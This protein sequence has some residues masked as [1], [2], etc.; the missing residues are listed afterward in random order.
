MKKL[1]AFFLFAGLAAIPAFGDSFTILGGYVLPR[2]HSDVYQQ[3]E[4]ETTFRVSDLN[5]FGGTVRYDKFLG[6]FVNI[7]GGVSFYDDTTTVSD[8]DF[9][10]TDGF[11]VLRDI[12]LEIV[13]LE[14][15]I[16]LLPAG[17][18]VPVIPYVGGGFGLYYWRYEEVGDF[19]NN[20]NGAN[21]TIITG[22]AFSDGWDPGFHIEGGV[23]IPVGRSLA[24][25]GEAKYWQAHG[26]LDPIG[27]DPS[28]EPLDLSG[29]Q[30]S[31]GVSI[32]F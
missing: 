6:N 12:R 11:P 15:S 22:R 31:G 23:H 9:V 1:L 26:N 17:R 24:V 8:V 7:S 32:W 3:N 20:R 13:P 5:N 25:V 4:R 10:H 16:H 19:I 29:T 27:F 14:A 30:Y 18:N 28:F 2:G 21:P